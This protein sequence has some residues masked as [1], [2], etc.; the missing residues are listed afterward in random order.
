[1][2]ITPSLNA[3]AE[4]GTALLTALREC[5]GDIEGL[6]KT[7]SSPD[8]ALPTVCI[9]WSVRDEIGH[10]IDASELLTRSLEQAETGQLE[11]TYRPRAMAPAMLSGAMERA[12]LLPLAQLQM[13]FS[14]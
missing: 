6:F 4:R 9:G 10:L 11:G 2:S 13:T 5:R 1:M 14:Q 12:A 8:L 3:S 7:L